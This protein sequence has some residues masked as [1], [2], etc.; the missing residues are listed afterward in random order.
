MSGSWVPTSSTS[1][2]FPKRKLTERL[3]KV[4]YVTIYSTHL[5]PFLLFLC[6]QKQ[7]LKWPPAA[8]KVNSDAFVT[9]RFCP[10]AVKEDGVF[11]P[12]A[13]SVLLQ[14]PRSEVGAYEQHWKAASVLGCAPSVSAVSLSAISLPVQLPAP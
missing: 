4:H 8:L 9:A 10:V 13:R 3:I 6:E 5:F 7:Q 12:F 2:F 14:L 11:D 1:H